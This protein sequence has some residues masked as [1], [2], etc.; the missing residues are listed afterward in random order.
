MKDNIEEIL[1]LLYECEE[2]GKPLTEK[3]LR[4]E[5]PELIGDLPDVIA[6]GLAKKGDDGVLDMT[7]PGRVRATK[8]VRLHRLAERLL[9]DVLDINRRASEEQ[10]CR[11]EHCL[12]DEVAESI[13]TLLGHPRTCPHGKPIPPGDCCNDERR[14]FDPIA[15]SLADLPC[16]LDAR[17]LYI[18]T[19]RHE[20]L[21]RLAA[22]GIL[23]GSII[24]LHQRVPSY[25]V[26]VGQTTLAID[27]TVAR[28]IFVRRSNNPGTVQPPSR[29]K[30]RFRWRSGWRKSRG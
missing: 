11:F 13:C 17:V 5:R 8:V 15:V 12:S 24:R 7:A 6:N 18:S 2:D 23:P 10:A 30:G 25:V 9:E 27:D 4:R 20:R 3:F 29:A 19:Q 26:Q 16:G 14:A 22:M 21:D 1:E 28:D